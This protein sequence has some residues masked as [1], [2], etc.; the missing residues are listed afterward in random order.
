MPGPHAFHV[1]VNGER[2]I[3]KEKHKNAFEKSLTVHSSELEINI[4]ALNTLTKLTRSKVFNLNLNDD[5]TDI[6]LEFHSI[7]GYWKTPTVLS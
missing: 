7:G 5:N 4:I 3:E 6:L 1:D 2:V